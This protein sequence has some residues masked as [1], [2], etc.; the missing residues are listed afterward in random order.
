MANRSVRGGK[1]KKRVGRK[2]F[3]T[4]GLD[5]R[6]I[7][8]TVFNEFMKTL[9]GERVFFDYDRERFDLDRSRDTATEHPPLG[10]DDLQIIANV[11]IYEMGS[12]LLRH[13]FPLLPMLGVGACKLVVEG[14]IKHGDGEEENFR[15]RASRAG[16]FSFL[17][18]SGPALMERN[19]RK[20]GRGIV[21]RIV[22]RTI[23]RR[24][25][26]YD[27][28]RCTSYGLLSGILSLIPG[29][30]LMTAPLGFCSGLIGA[31]TI[32]GRGLPR[33]PQSLLALLLNAVGFLFNLWLF[34]PEYFAA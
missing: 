13:L 8:T 28:H 3:L 1:K 26:N 2:C 24:W 5:E 9:Q 15:I 6:N 19:A 7:L 20:V 11:M 23:G 25:L 10:P 16:V 4:K 12:R 27:G 14:E 22:R 21:R 33:K 32:F 31:V 18:G 34:F 17:G 30:G 29:V